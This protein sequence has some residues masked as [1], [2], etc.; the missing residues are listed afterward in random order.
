[1][2]LSILIFICLLFYTMIVAQSISYII[3]LT[4]VQQKMNIEEYISF[5]KITDKNFRAKFA[6]AFYGALL[7]N[8]SLII[9]TFIYF[10]LKLVIVFT[11]SFICLMIDT[12]ITLKGNMP[13]NN[14]INTWTNE[15]YP[16]DWEEHRK[17]WLRYFRYRQI[18]NLSGYICLIIGIVFLR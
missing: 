9:I 6:Y 7:S 10:D 14:A 13:I 18:A 3:S 12:I 17:N 15:N 8:F 2:L 11:I 16:G 1:M 4:D 5:R